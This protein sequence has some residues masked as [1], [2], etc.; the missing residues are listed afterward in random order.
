MP[1]SRRTNGMVG[2]GSLSEAGTL[3][4]STDAARVAG[5]PTVA[6]F[7]RVRVDGKFLSAGDTR[8]WVR[9]VTYGPFG[10]AGDREYH[11][12]AVVERDFAR[13]AASGLNTVRTYTVPPRWL[14]D[15]AFRAH[16][17]VLVGLPWEQHITFLDEHRRVRDIER[18]VRDGVRACAGHPAMLG[19]A[20]GNEIP[21][22]I[23]RWHGARAIE[24]FLRRLCDGARTE[25]P[26]SLVTYVNY[27]T[28]EYLE[29]PFLD[30]VSFNVYLEARESLEAYLA[31]LQNLS[32]ERPLLM[33]ELGLDSRRH[34]E[35]HQASVLDWQVR[36]TFAAGCAGCIVFAWTD[37]WHRGGHDIEDWDFG[38]VDRRRQP[39]RAFATVRR[40]FAESPF[41]DGVPWP[42]ISVV[43][44]SYNGARTIRGCLDALAVL[45]YPDYEVIVVNDGSTDAT[46]AIAREYD[47]RVI[48]TENRGLSAARNTGWQAATGEIVAYI[49]D[50]AYPDPH[51]LTYLAATFLRTSHA[52][53]G[54]PNIA[55]R[56]DGFI[57]DCVA[58]APGGPTHILLS[59]TEAEHIPG[60]NMAFRRD[61]LAAIGGFDAQFRTAGDDVDVC[62]RLSERGL[63]LGFSPGAMVWHR[64]RNSVRA[65]WRQQRGYGR[66]EALLERKWPDKYTTAG[67]ASWGGRIYGPGLTRMLTWRR[68]RV[69]HGVWGSALFQ[70]RSEPAPGPLSALPLMPEWYLIMI[71]LA[72]MTAVGLLARGPLRWAAVP[73]LL[74]AGVSVAQAAVSA[75][76]NWTDDPRVRHRGWAGWA[77]TALLHLVQPAARLRGRFLGGLTPW[78]R[79]VPGVGSPFPYS[80]AIWSERWKSPA[81]Y[82][83]ALEAMLRTH[84]ARVRRG[85]D[86]DRWDL[87]VRHG[88]L[89]GMR[90]R[91]TIEEHGAGRQLLRLR[92]SPRVAPGG[93]S[94][95]LTLAALATLGGGAAPVLLG[96]GAALVGIWIFRD[97]ADA[98]ASIV[99]ALE[100]GGPA[101]GESRYPLDA[102][103]AETSGIERTARA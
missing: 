11:H 58:G 74:G 21:A 18:R 28:T 40:A 48:S 12:A 5:A 91:H 25:D 31:R 100:D 17:R 39:K 89:G 86:F 16:L 38:L 27:P 71:A 46:E 68:A 62:W 81:E 56:G 70:S 50:D 59:D 9:G 15:A 69:Y 61:A 3:D 92:V 44:C 73:L 41:P 47:V 20:V 66:A 63:T 42:R 83:A 1:F 75:T 45:D 6:D 2:R 55:P 14:L 87:D 24:D 94:A 36:T 102:A 98:A 19:Y 22:P 52:G 43:L 97:C 77:L 33:T 64:R 99:R 34:G 79:R 90:V 65:Y 93:L 82:L 8:F 101:T 32:G 10:S 37:E 76:R 4:F 88:L 7:V 72:L 80:S 95:M 103:R 23:V 49:D 57:A 67:H 96:L 35:M 60:C 30:V 54:G 78:R 85:G 84:G 29:L 51:W 13:I 53:V 26:T